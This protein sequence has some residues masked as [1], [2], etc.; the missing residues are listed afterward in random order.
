[1]IPVRSVEAM[2]DEM[3]KIALAMPKLPRQPFSSVMK[4]SPFNGNVFNS[5]VK[6]TRG[7]TTPSVPS[8]GKQINGA[9]LGTW[10]ED[11]ANTVRQKIT[12]ALRNRL[13]PPS[14]TGPASPAAT[15]SA[16]RPIV[17]STPTG[18]APVVGTAG[19]V[20]SGGSSGAAR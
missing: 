13:K 14:V 7:L 15:A 18:G 5:S 6:P 17:G 8:I 19:S 3:Q 9:G 16:T 20:T 11:G 1:M 4:S 10:G 12:A 2:I